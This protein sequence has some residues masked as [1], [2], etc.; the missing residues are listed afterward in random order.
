MVEIV[1]TRTVKAG[2]VT[3]A[4]A[5]PTA[6]SMTTV[7]GPDETAPGT[8]PEIVVS[9]QTEM[10]AA[11][12]LNFTRVFEPLYAPKLAPMIVNGAPMGAEDGV[13]EAICEVVTP[14]ELELLN[15]A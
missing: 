15:E 10:G 4:T 6:R 5:A 9:F 2:V 3:A 11:I 13:M 14:N 12:P 8:V 1:G 7:A